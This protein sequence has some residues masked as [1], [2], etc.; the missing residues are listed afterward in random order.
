MPRRIQPQVIIPSQISTLVQP[1]G[2]GRSEVEVHVGVVFLP[3]AHAWSL[4]HRQ[5][6]QDDVD[7]CP[8]LAPHGVVE[9]VDE[10]GAGVAR[11]AAGEHLATGRSLARLDLIRTDESMCHFL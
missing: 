10:L 9:E 3:S 5:A 11:G 2:T 8:S 6:V 4:V 1:G 7:G